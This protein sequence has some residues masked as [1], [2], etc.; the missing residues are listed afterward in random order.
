MNPMSLQRPHF[1]TAS[2]L[3]PF[4]TSEKRTAKSARRKKKK[5]SAGMRVGGWSAMGFG[6]EGGRVRFDVRVFEGSSRCAFAVFGP[7][8]ADCGAA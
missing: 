1:V 5:K 8:R 2:A 3:F 6:R 4:S 7:S